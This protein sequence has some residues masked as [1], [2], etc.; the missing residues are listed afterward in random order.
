[1]LSLPLSLPLPLL[2]FALPSCLDARAAAP[3]L[4]GE[5]DVDM[6]TSTAALP[7]ACDLSGRSPGRVVGAGELVE[8]EH[9]DDM[10]A[11][12]DEE[13][14]GLLGLPAWSAEPWPFEDPVLL[15]LSPLFAF[16]WLPLLL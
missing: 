11:E 13:P 14:A 8:P 5:G 1:M 12:G 7:D 2:L 6:S 16:P 15:P 4:A 3:A 10:P 9:D